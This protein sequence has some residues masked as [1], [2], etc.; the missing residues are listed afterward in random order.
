[1]MELHVK[2]VINK[3]NKQINFSLPK[4]ILG[5]AAINYILKNKKLKLRIEK[6]W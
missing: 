1:M 3:R 6:A 5:K 4:R 2:P